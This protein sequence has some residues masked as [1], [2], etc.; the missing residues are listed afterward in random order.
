MLR[1]KE[2]WN[3]NQSKYPQEQIDRI[4]EV[5][6]ASRRHRLKE[7]RAGIDCLIIEENP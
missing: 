7:R 4:D 3:N 5:H 1:E 6:S 2:S